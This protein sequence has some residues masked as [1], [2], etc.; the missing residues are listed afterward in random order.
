MKEKELREAADCA[1]CRKP[2]GHTGLPLFWRI[3]VERLGVKLDVVRRQDHLA[4][5]LGSPLLA[6]HMGEDREMTQPMMQPIT[7]TICETCAMDRQYGFLLPVLA[8]RAKPIDPEP[9]GAA[10]PVAS[11]GAVT[12]TI[13]SRGDSIAES[14]G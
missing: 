7:V 4:G 11:G 14:K 1:L 3:T 10:D 6:M 5:F 9:S 12:A 13:H 8:E 2:F